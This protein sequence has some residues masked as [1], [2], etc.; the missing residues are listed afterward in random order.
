MVN[1]RDW[2]NIVNQLYLNLKINNFKKR[3]KRTKFS[4]NMV[5]H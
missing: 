4:L 2:Q 3:N 5:F 1:G